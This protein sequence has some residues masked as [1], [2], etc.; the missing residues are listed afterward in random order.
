M[1]DP[2]VTVV[3]PTLEGGQPL[4][5]CL[6]SLVRQ[7]CNGVE[8]IVVDNSERGVA[9]SLVDRYAFRLIENRRNLGFGAAV[10][11]GFS[12]ARSPY[13]ATLN[14]D[15][16]AHARWLEVLVEAIESDSQ[17]GMCASQVRLAGQS[18]LDSAG[19]LAAADGST[20]QRGHG[21]SPNLFSQPEE[22]LFPSA[23]AALFRSEMIRQIGGFDEDFF[24]YCEDADLGFRARWAGWKC[25]YVPEAVVEHR[26]S[27]SAG[28]ASP[29]KAYYVE[30]NRLYLVLKNF[31][32]L[33]LM[34]VPWAELV[35]YFWHFYWMLKGRGLA[36]EFRRS[37]SSGWLLP[38]IVIRAHLAAFFRL[39]GL[40]RKRRAILRTAQI[41]TAEF[42][43]L[44][45]R[46]SISAREVAA[47]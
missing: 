23:S 28:R 31:P 34:K 13:L 24:L 2:I 20:K 14:D 40:L 27:H 16:V 29:L 11:Q 25:L 46:F 8:V 9:R 7:S 33:M 30:R 44:L 26:Y 47:Q 1:P 45:A 37:G 21:Q 12:I 39:R 43:A 15:A 32:A 38:W 36:R 18:L 4:E 22:V 6:L 42:Q 41:S 3:V 19:M 5:E 35:R 17:A 10:N